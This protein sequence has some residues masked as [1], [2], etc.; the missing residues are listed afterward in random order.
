MT[1]PMFV[2]TFA[3]DVPQ[4]EVGATLL[5]A[6]W[7]AEAVHGAV[8]VRLAAGYTHDP[9]RRTCV[10]AA[11]GRPGRDLNRVFAGLAG[12]E[13]G[14]AA[15]TVDRVV[16]AHNAPHPQSS[17]DGRDLVLADT[18]TDAADLGGES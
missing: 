2:Y 18:D 4:A 1:T 3:A 6:A 10:I 12:R 15:F 5:L 14:D 16:D 9:D 7:A 8:A 13:F 11:A 17:D